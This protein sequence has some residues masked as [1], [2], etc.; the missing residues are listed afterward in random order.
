MEKKII[1]P[2][3]WQD[4]YG[5][6]QANEIT[7]ARRILY[8][9][10][11]VAAD[12]DGKPMHPG[13]MAAQIDK[14]LDNI[15]TVLKG[16]G[17]SLSDVV[18]LNYYTTDVAAFVQAGPALAERLGKTGCRPASTL[19]GVASLYHPDVLVEIEATAAA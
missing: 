7:G 1:N 6:V 17:L 3:K 16:A 11:Q 5:F 9:A 2:W 8:C 14:A 4:Q 10:G 18:R 15:E 13:S 12:D 19:L